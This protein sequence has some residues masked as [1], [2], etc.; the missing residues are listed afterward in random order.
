M[1]SSSREV[2]DVIWRLCKD[3]R[4]A[5]ARLPFHGQPEL[6]IYATR[7]GNTKVAKFGL[8]FSQIGKDE[9]VLRTLAAEKR[10]EFETQGW[11]KG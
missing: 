2:E 8:I 5:E 6:R 1:S 7:E 9:R 3:G 11:V 10:V 4:V